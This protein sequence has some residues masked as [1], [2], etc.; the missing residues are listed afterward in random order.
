MLRT[1]L[2]SIKLCRGL[3]NRM[4]AIFFGKSVIWR[5]KVNKVKF[6]SPFRLRIYDFLLVFHSNICLDSTPF[7][8]LRVW[9]TGELDLSRT[10]RIKSDS[11]AGFLLVINGTYT[12]HFN[13]I[14]VWQ[15][16]DLELNLQCYSNENPVIRNGCTSNTFLFISGQQYICHNPTLFCNINVLNM[17]EIGLDL[18]GSL[19]VKS[20]GVIA[21]PLYSFLF[22]VNSNNYMT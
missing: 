5:F 20:N 9:N 10:L 11:A 12:S 3:K 14:W 1:H 8:R 15:M 19:Y 6:L 17:T 22:V 13:H 7:W 21:T 2:D 4:R 18:S 16:N